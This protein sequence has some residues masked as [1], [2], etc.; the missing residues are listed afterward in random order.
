MHYIT[1]IPNIASFFKLFT[2]KGLK[3]R[4]YYYIMLSYALCE[5]KGKAKE[6][7]IRA[8]A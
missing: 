8:Y 1:N 5:K 6:I 7:T 2:E 4:Y 3:K